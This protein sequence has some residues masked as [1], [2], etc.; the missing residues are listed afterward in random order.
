MTI[1]MELRMLCTMVFLANIQKS[2]SAFRVRDMLQ[3]S[4]RRFA[5][6][7]IPRAG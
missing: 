5:A 6:G 1:K 2:I 7:S 3:N 4:R